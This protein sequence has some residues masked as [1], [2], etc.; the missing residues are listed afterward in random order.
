[1]S[2]TMSAS[3]MTLIVSVLFGSA[4]TNVIVSILV[5]FRWLFYRK[6][7]NPGWILSPSLD[8]AAGGIGSYPFRERRGLATANL[9]QCLIL[10]GLPLQRKRHSTNLFI[11]WMNITHIGDIWLTFGGYMYSLRPVGPLLLNRRWKRRRLL[12]SQRLLRSCVPVL[13]RT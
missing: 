11:C 8:L 2:T 13:T 6:F 9:A 7:G 10:I 4:T 3:D 1:M 5:L 12:I